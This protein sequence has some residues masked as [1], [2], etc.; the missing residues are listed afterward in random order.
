MA[1]AEPID[2]SSVPISTNPISFP[3]FISFYIF[4]GLVEVCID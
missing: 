2:C 4:W 1:T 3:T